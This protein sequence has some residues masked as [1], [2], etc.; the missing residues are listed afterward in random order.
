VAVAFVGAQLVHTRWSRL[1]ALVAHPRKIAVGRRPGGFR[2]GLHAGA[3]G[4][5]RAGSVD[6]VAALVDGVVGVVVVLDVEV[7]GRVVED[8][9][10][11]DVVVEGRVV[12]VS[13][14]RSA[15]ARTSP[16]TNA[17]TRRRA[18]ASSRRVP[19]PRGDLSLVGVA[20]RTSSTDS[21]TWLRS[22]NVA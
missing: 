20:A 16:T 14:L 9:A 10:V 1:S 12:T 21:G 3:S 19:R 6:D 8:G 18:A 5:A 15:C 11:V 7:T 22:T 4:R 17:A 2:L 13:S